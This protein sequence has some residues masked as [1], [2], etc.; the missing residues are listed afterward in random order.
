MAFT[1]SQLKDAIKDY[2]QNDETT[3]VSNLPLFIRL[4]EE[5]ILKSVQLTFFRKNQTAAMAI[6]EKYLGLP[7]DFLAPYSLGFTANNVETFLEFKDVNFVQTF[8]ENPTSTGVPIYYA[9]FDI[10]TFIVGPTPDANYSVELHYFY[11][12]SSLTSGSE[13]STSW[14]SENA[15]LAMLYGSLVEAYTYMKGEPDMVQNYQSRMI[16]SMGALKHFGEAKETTDQ[17]RTGMVIRQKQ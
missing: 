6:G 13:S 8:S 17:Y 9:L 14:L 11:R 12:P 7:S 1:F 3:F 2:T 16:E 15:E 4:A 10:N 5:R